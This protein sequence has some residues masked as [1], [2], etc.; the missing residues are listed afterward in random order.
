MISTVTF[1][2]LLGPHIMYLFPKQIL[3]VV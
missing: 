3:D 2:L 1:C